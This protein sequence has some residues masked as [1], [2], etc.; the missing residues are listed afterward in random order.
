MYYATKKEL[1]HATGVDT[2]DFPAKKH[3]IASKTEFDK[4]GINKLVNVPTG[5]NDLKTKIGDLDGS[6]LK[7]VP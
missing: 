2:Y 4:L 7:T 1:E 6:K 5:L 3:F